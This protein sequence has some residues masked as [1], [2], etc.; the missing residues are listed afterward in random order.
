MNTKIILKNS[1]EGGKE[2]TTSDLDLG[3]LAVNTYDGDI[4]LKTDKDGEISINRFTKDNPIEGVIYVQK[5][6]SDANRGDSWDAAYLTIEKAIEDAWNRD[7]AIILIEIGPGLYTTRGHIDMPDNSIIHCVYRSVKIRPELGYE[8]RNVFRMGSGCF[9]EGPV[10]EGFRVDDFDNPTEGFAA[11]FREGALITRT[12]YVHKIA[13]RSIPNWSQ[14]APPLDRENGNPFVPRGGGVVLAD[15]AIISPYSIYPN[16]MTWGATPVIH[17]GIGYVAKNGGLVN[18]VNA[19]S[20][21]AHKHFL[22]IDGGQIILSACST[23]FG[24]YTLVSQGTRKII[25]SYEIDQ[26]VLPLTAEAESANSIYSSANTIIDAMYEDLVDNGFTNYDLSGEVSDPALT[27]ED[28]TKRDANLFLRSIT[29]ALASAN[30]KPSLDFAKGFFDTKGNATFERAAYDVEKCYRDTQLIA[31]SVSYDVLFGSNYSSIIAGKAYY[32][33]TGNTFI[34]EQKD[35][36]VLALQEQRSLTETL[37]GANTAA[38]TRSNSSFNEIIN[39]IE[40][41]TEFASN[42]IIP[43]PTNYDSGFFEARRLILSNKDFIQDEVIAWI[44]DQISSNTAPFSTGFAYDTAVCRRDVGF[45]LDSLF[46]DLTYRGN[47]ATYQSAVAYFIGTDAQYGDGE[48]APMIASLQRLQNILGDITQTI[49]I[50]QSSTNSGIQDVS[51]TPGSQEAAVFSQNRVGEIISTITSDGVA[52]TKIIPDTTWPDQV[53]QDAFADINNNKDQ[54]SNSVLI[55]ITLETKSL[56]GAFIRSYQFMVN[57]INNNIPN[58]TT[59]AKAIAN[60]LVDNIIRTL[61]NPSRREEPSVITA[62]GHTWTAIM[63]GVALTKMPPA[64]NLTN[65]TESILELDRGVVIASG[66]DDQGSALFVGGMEINADTGEL[67]GPPFQQ[68]VN[69]IS[70]RA[71]ISRSF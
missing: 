11:V 67:S 53:Y 47:L 41:G 28:Y 59:E 6:G 15:G 17:N 16:I 55:Y 24:D 54:I 49:G 13:V 50:T 37:L 9:I 26:T 23:Q 21:W 42:Y 57:Q 62:V 52:P 60:A 48:K 71:A 22:A 40:N 1:Q 34:S 38:V 46:Y 66:Q 10:F 56:L 7:G 12:P 29:W 19:I 14:V 4:Y 68:A 30:E 8:E 58:V 36:T 44:D 39:I 32:R 33:G 51:G 2:P 3:E 65:I 20:I 69:R 64:A 70:T 27:F 45:I 31:D 18:A 25:E 43:D 5:N 61:I 35:A 63:S